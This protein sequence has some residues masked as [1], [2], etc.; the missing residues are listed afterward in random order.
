VIISSPCVTVMNGSLS[1]GL[2]FHCLEC[3]RERNNRWYRD[4]R[5]ALGKDVRD[6]SWV[7]DGF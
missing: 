5:R 6:H 2:S 3:N 7:P 1:D 4:S